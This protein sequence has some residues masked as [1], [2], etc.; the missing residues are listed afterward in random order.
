MCGFAELAVR[1][2]SL[3]W[4]VDFEDVDLVCMGVEFCGG[5]TRVLGW[6]FRGC[7][8]VA[9]YCGVVLEQMSLRGVCL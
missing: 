8:G 1:V 5:L 6:R 9:E 3:M 2:N 4:A 7:M